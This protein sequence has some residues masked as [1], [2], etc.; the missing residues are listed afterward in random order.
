M[1][2]KSSDLVFSVIV[3]LH[4]GNSVVM[5]VMMF[6]FSFVILIVLVVVVVVIIIIVIAFIYDNATI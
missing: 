2:P 3:F 1:M 4:D 5:V 6:V